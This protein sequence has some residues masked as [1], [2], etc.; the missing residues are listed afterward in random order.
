MYYKEEIINGILCCKHT[1][2]GAWVEKTKEELTKK[3]VKLKVEI[4]RLN[5]KLNTAQK[6]VHEPI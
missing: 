4:D 3:I 2:D 6:R 5:N 1:P